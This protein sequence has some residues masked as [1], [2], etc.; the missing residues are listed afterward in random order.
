MPSQPIHDPSILALSLESM[1]GDPHRLLSLLREGGVR[2]LILIPMLAFSLASGQIF[3][4][5]Y[6]PWWVGFFVG[7]LWGAF[8]G[9]VGIWFCGKLFYIFFW[10]ARKEVSPS[11]FS[12][13]TYASFG[14]LLFFSLTG[15][16]L[17][18][19]GLYLSVS[20]YSG[21]AFMILGILW[22]GFSFARLVNAERPAYFSTTFLSLLFLTSFLLFVSYLFPL[23]YKDINAF[24]RE[25]EFLKSHI[26]INE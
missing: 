3:S 10:F 7:L 23:V 2:R 1:Y 24:V 5:N 26:I 13:L 15:M 14:P 11:I 20:W 8:F 21:Y 18:L 9:F 16:V 4:E 12:N 6:L 25:V 17:H 22:S 19:G